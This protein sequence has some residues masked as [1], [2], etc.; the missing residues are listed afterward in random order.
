MFTTPPLSLP[1]ITTRTP[2]KAASSGTILKTLPENA[3]EPVGLASDGEKG[4]ESCHSVTSTRWYHWGSAHD[5][6]RLCTFCYTYWR[7]YAGLKLPNKWGRFCACVSVCIF[8]VSVCVCVC[9]AVSRVC[10]Y[11]ERCLTGKLNRNICIAV[12]MVVCPW[13]S[14]VKGNGRLVDGKAVL[15]A[16][17]CKR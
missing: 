13:L 3:T 11:G 1:H 10:A 8:I 16:S 4:C 12:C 6:C 9:V 15:R 17:S 14:I 7:K 5:H 2:G